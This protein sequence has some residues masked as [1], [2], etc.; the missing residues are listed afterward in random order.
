MEKD[1]KAKWVA[2]LRSGKYKQGQGWLYSIIKGSPKFC[3]LGVLC[4]VGG[5][6]RQEENAKSIFSYGEK[7]DTELPPPKFLGEIGL[8]RLEAR[9]L[10]K[11]NDSGGQSFLQIASYIEANL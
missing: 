1:L 8:T 2:A 10:A 4:E 3:C 5:V 7:F 9:H 11:M 6:T